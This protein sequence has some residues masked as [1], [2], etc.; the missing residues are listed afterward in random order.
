MTEHIQNQ[1]TSV[2]SSKKQEI[3]SIVILDWQ[4]YVVTE[5]SKIKPRWFRL[6]LRLANDAEIAANPLAR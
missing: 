3:G 2:A 6:S 4:A 1:N 5:I